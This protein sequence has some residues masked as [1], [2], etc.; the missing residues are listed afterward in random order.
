MIFYFVPSR[1]GGQEK[2]TEENAETKITNHKSKIGN[3]KSVRPTD[4][5]THDF[6]IFPI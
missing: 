5:S 2:P 4:Q 6:S 3:R 1:L